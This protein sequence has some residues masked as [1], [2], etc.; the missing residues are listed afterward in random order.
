MISANSLKLPV[1][2]FD[3][4]LLMPQYSQVES[5]NSVSLQQGLDSHRTLKIPIISSPMDTVTGLRMAQTMYDLGGLGII[6]RYNTIEEQASTAA[7]VS[8]VVGAAVGVSGDFKDRAAALRNVGV[9][10]LCVDVAH[11]HHVLME[12]ALKTLKDAFG[13][14]VHI[15][16][17]NVATL[18]GFNDLA[19]WG[20]DSIR[21]G[22]GGGSICTTRI[23]TGHGVP[24][25][26]TIFECARSDRDA[27]II[28]DGGIKNSGDIVKAIAAGADFVM[29]GS[30][31]AGTTEAPGQVITYTDGSKR[32]AYRGMAS[33]KAQEAWR[34]KSSTPEGIATTIHY[35]G[36]V[37]NIVDDLVGGIK[38][39]CSYSG[40]FTLDEL[41]VKAQFTRQSTAGSVES[42]AHILTRG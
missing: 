13:D 27:K 38:S 37:K 20:A 39:G 32:K 25:L 18:E 24:G 10:V 42:G 23:Q 9:S 33:R 1:L 5:R 35:K 2:T 29:L 16:A 15:M 3:D 41:R 4:V 28:I 6:H 36:A 31:L 12:R 19:D 30:L 40:A 17:G 21:C 34:G 8:G 26:E 11:G 7:S 14:E 22:I